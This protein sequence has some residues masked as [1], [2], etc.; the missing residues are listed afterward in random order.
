MRR[1]SEPQ[2]PL[3][4]LWTRARRL[5]NRLGP[6]LYQLPPRWDRNAERL[7]TFLEQVPDEP[8]AIEFRDARWYHPETLD[9][10]RDACV[11]LCLHDMDGS[12]TGKMAVGPFVYAAR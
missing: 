6:V 9:L 11:A 7:R 5:G 2:E 8:Q 10:L 3:R 4:R 1:L 12:A